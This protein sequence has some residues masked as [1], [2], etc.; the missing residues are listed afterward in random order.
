MVQLLFI[1]LIG[2]IWNHKNNTYILGIISYK[3]QCSKL[4]V[5]KMA[6]PEKNTVDYFPHDATANSGVTITIIQNQ[7][8][9]DGY[10][11]WFKLLER[12]CSTEYHVIDCRNP[13]RWQFLLAITNVKEDTA[14]KLLDTLSNLDAIDKELW[15]NKIIWC[16]NLI[17]RIADV[18]VNRNRQIPQKPRFYNGE[19]IVND[20]PT[21][22]NH[23]V[24]VVSTDESTQ[25]KLK[26][27]KVNKTKRNNRQSLEEYIL[28]L[29]TEFQEIDID[30]EIKKCNLWWS[31]GKRKMSRPKTAYHNWMLK[32]MEYKNNHHSNQPIPNNDLDKFTQG[33]YGNQVQT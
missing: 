3:P 20:I 6:R 30:Q 27:T 21:T 19:L 28:E 15:Q 26:E 32:A 33:K 7:F 31:D 16:Q 12:L 4:K 29:K 14:C 9:N 1:L 17:N 18:Y 23:T 10:A 11:F 25:K 22:N 24:G 2:K 8:G 5:I 13:A